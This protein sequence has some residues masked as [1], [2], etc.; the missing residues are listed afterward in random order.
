M[1]IESCASMTSLGEF[2]SYIHASYIAGMNLLTNLFSILF[3]M[4]KANSMEESQKRINEALN[5]YRIIKKRDLWEKLTQEHIGWTVSICLTKKDEEE[6]E[7]EWSKVKSA[8]LTLLGSP[9]DKYWV[10]DD[11]HVIGMDKSIASEANRGCLK[12]TKKFL[13]NFLTRKLVKLGNRKTL[14]R[15]LSMDRPQ[16]NSM[17]LKKG[18]KIFQVTIEES[19]PDELA[20]QQWHSDLERALSAAAGDPPKPK[21]KKGPCP[22]RCDFFNYMWFKFAFTTLL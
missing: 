21:Y 17:Q 9:L 10:E 4:S 19:D 7:R 20:P 5:V 2:E 18:E 11:E 3:E 16:R 12:K 15:N 14:A 8:E 22:L 13:I 6:F 1:D